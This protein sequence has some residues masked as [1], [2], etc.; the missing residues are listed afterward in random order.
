MVAGS[1]AFIT[2]RL[3]V[4]HWP[5]NMAHFAGAPV[6][7]EAPHLGAPI[8]YTICIH[9]DHGECKVSDITP[10]H[11]Q[12]ELFSMGEGFVGHHILPPGDSLRLDPQGNKGEYSVRFE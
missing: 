10:E 3:S 1:S 11:K 12:L 5:V 6:T 4:H 2:V 9:M 8:Y 7:I